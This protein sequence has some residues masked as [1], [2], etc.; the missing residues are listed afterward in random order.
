MFGIEGYTRFYSY[1]SLFTF[2]MLGL[3]ISTNLFQM[4]FF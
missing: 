1:L 3:V 2:S 4:Y